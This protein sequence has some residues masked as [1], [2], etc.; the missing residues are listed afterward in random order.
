M[1]NVAR[2]AAQFVCRQI[3]VDRAREVFSPGIGHVRT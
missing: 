1:L 2:V 3:G